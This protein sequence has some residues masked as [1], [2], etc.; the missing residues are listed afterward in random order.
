MNSGEVKKEKERKKIMFIAAF[1]A[2][3]AVSCTNSELMPAGRT[4][5][6]T[7]VVPGENT[8]DTP[9]T[10]LPSDTGV[11]GRLTVDVA[12]TNEPDTRTT[13]DWPHVLWTSGDAICMFT[14]NDGDRTAIASYTYSGGTSASA[15]FVR[16]ADPAPVAEDGYY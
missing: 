6:G 15:E 16:A 5:T 1:A 11:L 12:D 4:Q 13:V 9:G 2:L 8:D 14:A 7:D 3:L 10:D